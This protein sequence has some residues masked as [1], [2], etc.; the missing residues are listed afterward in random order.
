MR[1]LVMVG[2]ISKNSINKQLFKNVKEL[3]DD[4]FEFDVVDIA[5]IP[6]YSQD[7]EDEPTTMA[8]DM[9]ARIE[10]CDGVLFV[11]PE[12]NRSIPGVLKNAIDWGS[13]P[14]GANSWAGKPA[15]IIGASIGTMGT[16]AAQNHLRQILTELSVCVMPT[17][18][19]YYVDE[20]KEGKLGGDSAERLK[21]L[22]GAFAVWIEKISGR[23]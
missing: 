21:K 9:K 22:L 13:R 14:Y 4:K 10:A 20:M 7:I 1:V 18:R 19:F 11:T 3:A 2:G 15:A 17:P 8:A 23:P 5:A 6:C 12:Y 16:F